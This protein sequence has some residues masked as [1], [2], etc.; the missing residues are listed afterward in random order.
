MFSLGVLKEEGSMNRRTVLALPVAAICLA[1]QATVANSAEIKVLGTQ[2]IQIIWNEV[3]PVFERSTGHRVTL[4]PNLSIATKKLIDSGE[5]FD[6]AIGIPIVI[7]QLIK[8]G[9]IVPATRTDILR[10]GTGVAVRAGAVKPDISTTEAFKRALLKAKSVAYLT[11]AT[12]PGRYMAELVKRL[13]I[14]EQL[15]S[16]TL[17][18]ETDIVGPMV[19]KGEVELGITGIA[20]LIETPGINL[21]G[22]LPAEIQ[23]YN[24]FT[25]GIS[26][27]TA[28]ADASK[29]FIKFLSGPTA[30][31]VI[32]SKGM[33]PG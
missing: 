3:G 12:G 26:T 2:A 19:A 18:A 29:E 28:H 6:V 10:Q 17:L 8:E 22:P 30:V 16:K 25:G 24:V 1:L 27:S 5:S 14:A 7:D 11:T 15:Q 9:K 31:P 20:T 13:G 23:F 32:K 33:E 21:V 4:I